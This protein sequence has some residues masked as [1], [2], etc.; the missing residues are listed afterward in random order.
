MTLDDGKRKVLMLL[1][2]F[3]SGG[4]LTEDAD[5]NNKMADFVDIAQKEMAGYKKIIRSVKVKP[6]P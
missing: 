5:I 3:S 2:E 4:E 1:D 6:E